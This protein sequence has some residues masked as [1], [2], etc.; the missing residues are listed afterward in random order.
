MSK[1]SVIVMI[2][3]LL[4]LSLT[5]HAATIKN[6]TEQTTHDAAYK[7]FPY[8]CKL[9]NGELICVFYA[10]YGHLSLPNAKVPK[11]GRICIMRSRNNGRTWSEPQMLVDLD[12]DDR[13]PSIM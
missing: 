4:T 1:K 13:D 8:I 2:I 5:G 3:L 9:D 10:G 11:G 6:I 12:G 7:A